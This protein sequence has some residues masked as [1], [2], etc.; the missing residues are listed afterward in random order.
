MERGKDFTQD[1]RA[2]AQTLLD[3]LMNDERQVMWLSQYMNEANPEAWAATFDSAQE[4]TPLFDLG[5]QLTVRWHS[6]VLA[7]AIK[8]LDSYENVYHKSYKEINHG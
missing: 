1:I 2:A 7:Q 5:Y 6:L 4:D 8:D 3:H